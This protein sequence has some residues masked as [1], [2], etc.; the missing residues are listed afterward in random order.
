LG[1]KLSPATLCPLRQG[2]WAIW[3]LRT[4]S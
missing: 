1:L 2:V 3:P 4:E